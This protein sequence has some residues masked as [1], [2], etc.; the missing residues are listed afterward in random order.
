MDESKQSKPG[1]LSILEAKALVARLALVKERAIDDSVAADPYEQIEM[2][3]AKTKSQLTAER[4]DT[5]AVLDE[6]AVRLL[7]RG[8]E[9]LRAQALGDQLERLRKLVGAVFT[10]CQPTFCPC[11]GMLGSGHN[12]GCLWPTLLAE[13]TKS[14]A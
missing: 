13:A 9:D 11:C 8:P 2:S 6:C 7:A 3:T 5:E 12:A 14:E 10:V 1:D 4:M